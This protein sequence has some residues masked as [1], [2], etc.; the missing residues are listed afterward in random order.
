MGVNQGTK[1]GPWLFI[2]MINELDVS[3]TDLWQYVD[4]FANISATIR[5]NQ[6]S[7]IQAAVDILASRATVDRF[8]LN[9]TRCKELLVNF[10]VKNPTSFDPVVVNGLP[11]D[12]VTTAKILGLLPARNRCTPNLRNMRK[13]KPV[14]KTNRFHNSF[15]ALNSL[16]D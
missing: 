3:G 4:F 11:I 5:E 6:P 16:K 2:I 15:I 9:E 14:F 8:Q 10:N 12:L 7:H 1:Q 13:F